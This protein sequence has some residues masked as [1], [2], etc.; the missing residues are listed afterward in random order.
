MKGMAVSAGSKSGKQ[1]NID[2]S[3][4][5]NGWTVRISDYGSFDTISKSLVA[6]T[7][8]EVQAIVGDALS[9]KIKLRKRPDEDKDKG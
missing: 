5:D 3:Q 8:D 7:P 2:I 6:K 1:I 4:A 9:G